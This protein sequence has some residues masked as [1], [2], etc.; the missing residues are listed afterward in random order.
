MS[1]YKHQ[2]PSFPDSFKLWLMHRVWRGSWYC[3]VS[4][5]KSLLLPQVSVFIDVVQSHCYNQQL[6][7]LVSFAATEPINGKFSP[8][9]IDEQSPWTDNHQI[10]VKAMLFWDGTLSGTVT[11]QSR[12]IMQRFQ[13]STRIIGEDSAGNTVWTKELQGNTVGGLMNVSSS[14]SQVHSVTINVGVEEAQRTHHMKVF[15]NITDKPFLRESC[16]CDLTFRWPLFWIISFTVHL[17]KP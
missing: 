4:I 5:C 2:C 15:F 11:T 1:W 17:G 16:S 7:T 10:G 12:H 8:I 13:G 9:S 14:S 3:M 6:L